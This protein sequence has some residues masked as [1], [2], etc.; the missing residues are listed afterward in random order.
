MDMHKKLTGRD[1]VATF[2]QAIGQGAG[3]PMPSHVPGHGAQ[4]AQAEPP[5][6]NDAFKEHVRSIA[7][8]I[9]GEA[10]AQ[11]PTRRR[12]RRAAPLAPLPPPPETPVPED[13]F[14]IAELPQIRRSRRA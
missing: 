6:L 3:T 14:D 8:R 5:V 7:T 9:A 12:V 13:H 2:A 11:A 4:V 1:Y 10:P